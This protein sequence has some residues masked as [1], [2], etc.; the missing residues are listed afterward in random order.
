MNKGQ[1]SKPFILLFFSFKE[2]T[3]PSMKGDE[4]I[5]AVC[6]FICDKSALQLPSR[7]KHSEMMAEIGGSFFTKYS[8]PFF[9]LSFFTSSHPPIHPLLNLSV[10]WPVYLCIWCSEKG[11]GCLYA[12]FW[13]KPQPWTSLSL[14]HAILS[15][16]PER[17]DCSINYFVDSDAP[18]PIPWADLAF[19]NA[20]AYFARPT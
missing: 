6:V 19:S 18:V 2:S 12:A 9:D 3:L 8:Y 20:F 10:C 14:H 4:K 7:R 15:K 5:K 11:L 13:F 17:L 1:C 16:D